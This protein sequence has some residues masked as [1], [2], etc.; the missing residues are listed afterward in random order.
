MVFPDLIEA[1]LLATSL[2]EWM[3]A[4][5]PEVAAPTTLRGYSQKLW[6]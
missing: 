3:P 2:H 5:M 1:L 6:S 4:S